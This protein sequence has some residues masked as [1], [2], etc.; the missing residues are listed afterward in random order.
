MR[1]A[2]VR[3]ALA[4]AAFASVATVIAAGGRASAAD[5]DMTAALHALSTTLTSHDVVRTSAGIVMTRDLQATYTATQTAPCVLTIHLD[6]TATFTPPNG[7]VLTETP[8]GTFYTLPLATMSSSLTKANAKSSEQL[9]ATNE[10]RTAPAIYSYSGDEVLPLAGFKAA[11]PATVA[12]TKPAPS[13]PTF[14]TEA[15]AKAALAALTAA[16]TA[17][18]AP[19]SK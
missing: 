14:A 1:R 5:T 8:P 9:P 10:R 15:A 2:F 12:S 7:A 13:D 3:G 16:A 6:A 17:C 18:A 11:D 4:T 19:A